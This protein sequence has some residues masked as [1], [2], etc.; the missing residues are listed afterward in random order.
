MP[1][2]I[3][4]GLDGATLDL[5]KPWAD[6]GKLPNLAAFMVNGSWGRLESTIHPSTPQAWSTFITGKNAGKH[7]VFDFAQRELGTYTFRLMNGGQ[8]RATSLWQLLSRADYR[9]GVVNVPFTY[10]PERVNGFMLSGFDAPG[11]GRGFCQPET[12]LDEVI[13]GVGAYE[14]KGTFPVGR[15]KGWYRKERLAEVIE[16]RAEVTRF[17]WQKHPVDFYMMLFNELD[18]VQHLF[19]RS[20]EDGGKEE[21]GAGGLIEY[22][23]HQVDEMLGRLLREVDE[24]TTIFIISDHGAGPL[25]KVVY[26]NEWLMS[27]GFL[28]YHSAARSK[29][30][31]R[32]VLAQLRYMLKRLPAAYRDRLR[33]WF[34]QFKDSVDSYLQFG[35]IDWANTIAYSHGTYGSI[36][37]NLE[38]REP[39]GQ[40]AA[41][42]YET[43]RDSIVEKL[44]ELKEPSGELVVKR[45][46]K[47]EDLFRGPF[48]EEAPDLLVEW[49]DYAYYTH[50]GLRSPN[51]ALF[52]DE[53]YVDS[54]E[55]EHTGTH[56]LN[57][58]FMAR[59]PAIARNSKIDGARLL[60][61][62]PT[63]LYLMGCPIPSGMDGKVLQDL[64]DQ[65]YLEK[66]PPRYREDSS[67]DSEVDSQTGNYSSDE[68][69]AMRSRLRGLGY[70]D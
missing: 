25:R 39:M 67:V 52:G 4:F 30:S 6:A 15:K 50:G 8:R 54:S 58:V 59:G 14:F 65:T 18:H 38:G 31:M 62:T 34:P 33:R 35:S 46:H 17:L 49:S 45:V 43:V 64:F 44:L 48:F 40:V 27:Q 51:G 10:P 42:E 24:D 63:I 68:E 26:L 2:V 56:R 41:S 20:M 9:V 29:P 1:K 21:V 28:S 19:W 16:N 11:T 22:A 23:Y 47:R 53:L 61:V 7:S 32:K 3:V 57:G 12:I 66:N 13:A 37:L 60:D 55:F 69:E 5:I 70:V 36:S